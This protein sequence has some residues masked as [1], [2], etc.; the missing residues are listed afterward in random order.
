MGGKRR[1]RRYTVVIGDH[2]KSRTD[3]GEIKRSISKIIVHRDW[4]GGVRADYAIIVL[5]NTVPTSKS[6]KTD[7]LPPRDAVCR[8]FGHQMVLSGWG[9]DHYDETRP[10]NK[11]WAVL[12]TCMPIYKCPMVANRERRYSLCGGDPKNKKNSGCEGDSGG[13]LT[14]TDDRTGETTI[15]GVVSSLG[16]YDLCLDTTLY[17]R[18]AEPSVLDW[19]RQHTDAA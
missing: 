5:R 1:S 4:R 3:S 6:I 16:G 11:L 9:D 18:V 17:A 12:Q 8:Q 10:T 2:D 15:Y 7:K 14:H 19:I 13:P